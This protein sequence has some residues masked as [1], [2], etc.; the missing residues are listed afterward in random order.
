MLACRSPKSY[1][2]VPSLTV[3]ARPEMPGPILD[4]T[5]RGQCASA[6]R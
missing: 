4:L 3:G 2:V 6:A 5:P 1:H